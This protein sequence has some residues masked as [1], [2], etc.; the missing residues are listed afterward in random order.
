MTLKIGDKIKTLRKQQNITQE[1]L[2]DYLNISYQAVSKWENGLALPDI[3][4]IPALSNFFGVTS[5]FLLGIKADENEEKINKYYKQAMDCSHTGE[6]EKGIEIIKEALNTYP[7][8]SKLLSLLIGFLFGLFCV[9]GQKDLLKEIVAKSE[10]VLQDST[11]EEERIDVLEKLAYSYNLLEMQ[12][13]A[14]E[15]ANRLPDTVV[16][17]QEVLSNILMPMSKRKEKQQE[18]VFCNFEVMINHILWLGGISLGRKEFLKAIDIYSRVI[19]LIEN[20]GN[21][22]FFLLR[23]AGAHN[24]LAM[25]YSS[26]GDVDKAYEN[27]DKVIKCYVGFEETLKSGKYSYKTPMLDTLVFS[28]DNLHANSTV[29]EF[30][31]WYAKIGH[32]YKNYFEAVINDKRFPAL[33]ERVE[34]TLAD[35][36]ND[37]L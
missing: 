12:D 20:I 2:A 9:N 27:I 24:G 15:T 1:K 6:I 36:K 26:T 7:N 14:I 31:D 30:E 5:D 32:D 3:S 22:G 19:I 33:R 21:E 11:N 28:R 23:S 25:A 34:K 8:N 35:I 10:L 13:K 16:N 29:T 37:K 17:K 18:C 4:L